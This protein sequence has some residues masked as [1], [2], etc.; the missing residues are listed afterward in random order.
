MTAILKQKVVAAVDRL[1]PLLIDVAHQI[2]ANPELGHEEEFAHGLLTKVLA[3]AGLAVQRSAHD[4]ATAFAARAGSDGPLI[5]VLCE[6]DALPEIGHACG[7]NVIAAAGLGAGLAAAGVA[8]E[9]G[10]RL[11]VL[12][13]PSEERAPCGKVLLG[14]RG[15]F[16]G[17]AAALI[18]HPARN[19]L[20]SI[21]ALAAGLWR[22]EYFG[23]PA[24]VASAPEL[25]RNALDAAVFGYTAIAA[26]RQYIGRSER[27]GGYFPEAGT[28]TNVVPHHTVAQWAIRS[29]TVAGLERL[30]PRVMAC[31]EA[32][33][34]AAGCRVEITE[35][36]RI[37]DV[38][39]NPVLI[40]RYV[41]NM[42]AL[43][44][45]VHDPA[46]VGG[47]IASTDMGRVSYLVPSIHPMIKIAPG[48]PIH[49][50]EFAVHACSAA[51]DAAVLDAAKA[52]AM[53]VVDLWTEPGLLEAVTASFRAGTE[54]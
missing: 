48:T 49:D 39:T 31:L 9:A 4:L 53:T 17:V 20:R 47:L 50:P 35:Q 44:R 25:G 6:Y 40:E 54:N 19:D 26:L 1:A 10:G 32:G 22:V 36:A 18:V 30:V 11:L 14:E 8:A 45:P 2:H 16:D 42:T 41:A 43:G 29:E 23:H 13:T 5:A 34:A 52:M 7:H 38:R 15:A 28:A 24:H 3:E 37:E 51:A 12:G 33:A 21:N 46:M 27:I